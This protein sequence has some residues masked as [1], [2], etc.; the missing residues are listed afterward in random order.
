MKLEWNVYVKEQEA[1]C[2][3]NVFDLSSRFNDSLD[4]LRKEYFKSHLGDFEWFSK[5]LKSIAMYSYW[6]KCEYEIG[7]TS[8]P[9][10]VTREAVKNVED[11]LSGNIA[12]FPKI[13]EKIDVYNQLKLNWNQFAK[14]VFDNI[15]KARKR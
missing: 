12:L 11:T 5:E 13:Y 6:G 3:R 9:S 8:W 10:Y 15:K 1:I 14:Y 4:K 2:V 7:L